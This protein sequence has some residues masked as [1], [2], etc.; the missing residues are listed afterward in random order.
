MFGH[1]FVLDLF[2]EL[3]G[4]HDAI[5]FSVI[6]DSGRLNKAILTELIVG[7]LMTQ[8]TV[9]GFIAKDLSR[10]ASTT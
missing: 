10:Y 3:H 8:I 1:Y 4:L 7:F 6:A 5:R 2:G 9:Q